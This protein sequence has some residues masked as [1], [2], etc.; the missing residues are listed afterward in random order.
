MEISQKELE[1]LK[2]AIRAE[3]RERLYAWLS[4]DKHPEFENI[5]KE[6]GEIEDSCGGFYDIED[7]REHLPEEFKSEDLTAYIK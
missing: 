7:I 5:V 1:Q 6:T 3:S 2:K 4:P